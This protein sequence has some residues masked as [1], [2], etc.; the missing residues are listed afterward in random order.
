[1]AWDKISNVFIV[2]VSASGVIPK[3]SNVSGVVVVILIGGGRG[4]K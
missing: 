2:V 3:A 1:L 4:T